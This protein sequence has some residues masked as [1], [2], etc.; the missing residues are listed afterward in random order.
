MTAHRHAF[1]AQLDR[2]VE[3]LRREHARH[4]ER[5]MGPAIS[6]LLRESFLRA[7]GTLIGGTR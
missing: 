1:A 5:P 6:R 7:L 2:E 3:R 4:P